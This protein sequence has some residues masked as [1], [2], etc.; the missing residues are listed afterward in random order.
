MA[1][2][3][4]LFIDSPPMRKMTR[5]LIDVITPF[6]QLSSPDPPL[7]AGALAFHW[8]APFPFPELRSFAFTLPAAVCGLGS[9][10]FY[11]FVFLFFSAF[12]ELA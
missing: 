11:L 10:F 12:R 7:M 6:P 4:R 8:Q 2:P 3:G 5:T 1:Q 9:F